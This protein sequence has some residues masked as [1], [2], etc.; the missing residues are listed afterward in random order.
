MSFISFEITMGMSEEQCIEEAGKQYR[1]IKRQQIADE[2]RRIRHIER[3]YSQIPIIKELIPFIEVYRQG[4]DTRIKN[5]YEAEI[6]V[7]DDGTYILFWRYFRSYGEAVRQEE[8]LWSYFLNLET[9]A[10]CLEDDPFPYDL[11][12]FETGVRLS[13]Y[14]CICILE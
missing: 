11:K 8:M 3:I 6:E 4:N 2:N 7:C 10:H 13:L 14:R 9:I 5:H 12:C 1:R